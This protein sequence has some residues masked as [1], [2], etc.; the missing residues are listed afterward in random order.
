[1]IVEFEEIC[2]Y[3][4]T[5][6]LS[7][8]LLITALETFLAS[9]PFYIPYAVN[10]INYRLLKTPAVTWILMNFE[11]IAKFKNLKNPAGNNSKL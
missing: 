6:K 9:G 4:I 1:M 8:S 7:D 5:Y 11:T 2:R 3:F 10:K